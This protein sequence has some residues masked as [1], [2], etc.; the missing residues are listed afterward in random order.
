MWNVIDEQDDSTLPQVEYGY[1]LVT[2]EYYGGGG[3]RTVDK[4]FY[5]QDREMANKHTDCTVVNIKVSNLFA[6]ELLV[7]PT[8]Y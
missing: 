6:F 4:S 8:E 1:F 5:T 2:L 7:Q 3:R